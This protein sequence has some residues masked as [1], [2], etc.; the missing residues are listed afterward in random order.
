MQKPR[1][2]VGYYSENMI[3]PVA[4]DLSDLN[5]HFEIRNSL[6][7]T[8]GIPSLFVKGRRVIEFGPGSGHNALFTSSLSPSRYVL[9]DGNPTGIAEV[10]KLFAK[11]ASGQSITLIESYIEEFCSAEKFDLVLCEGVIPTQ[12]E[13][14]SFLKHVASFATVGGIV[15]ITCLDYVSCLSEVLRRFVSR[16]MSIQNGSLQDN[17]RNLV[18]IW[19]DHLNS[20]EGMTRSHEDWIKDNMLQPFYGPLFSIKDAVESLRES[21]Y[22]YNSSPSFICDWRWFKTLHGKEA[23]RVNDIALDQYLNNVHNL[24]DYRFVYPK[25]DVLLNTELI[26][27]CTAVYDEVENFMRHHD[28]KSI[29]KVCDLTKFIGINLKSL[30]AIYPDVFSDYRSALKAIVN[31]GGKHDFRLFTTFFGRGQQYVSFIRN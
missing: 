25:R 26:D 22:V 27:L 9:V 18:P 20:L 16:C 14:V 24:V 17:V 23:G 6:Y 30:N 13:P 7:R 4:Q 2:F 8:L 28:L 12:V 11:R 31:D 15:V 29:V 19:K 1:P 21:F 3:S 10:N 5:R